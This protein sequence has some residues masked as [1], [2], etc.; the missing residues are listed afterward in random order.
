MKIIDFVIQGHFGNFDLELYEIWLVCA[1][2]HHRFELESPNLHQ[3]YIFGYS[4]MVL[5]MKVIDLDLQGHFGN[6]GLEF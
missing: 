6:F 4:Q 5:K 1:I 2:T 3:P